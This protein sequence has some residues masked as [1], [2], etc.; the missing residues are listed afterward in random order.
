MK[1][2]NRN[3]ELDDLYDEYELDDEPQRNPVKPIQPV[4]AEKKSQFKRDRM[5]IS[6]M[7]MTTSMMI[8]TMMII[9]MMTSTMIMMT[10]E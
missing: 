4:K 8:S 10:K 5:M 2:H 7:I 1:L 3:R 9:M 6:K